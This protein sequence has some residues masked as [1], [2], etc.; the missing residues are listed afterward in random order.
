[1][2]SGYQGRGGARPWRKTG[3]N[4]K[5]SQE[6]SDKNK[7]AE[8]AGDRGGRDS[9]KLS[10]NLDSSGKEQKIEKRDAKGGRGENP[11]RVRSLQGWQRGE[12]II[13]K[14]ILGTRRRFNVSK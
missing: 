5:I 3:P 10:P 9:I 1:V 13:S 2:T 12:K 6:E 4:K 7:V 11:N 14:S 8:T